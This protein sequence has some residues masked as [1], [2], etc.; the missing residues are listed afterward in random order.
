MKITPTLVSSFSMRPLYCDNLAQQIQSSG[1]SS[2]MFET[3]TRASLSHRLKNRPAKV[4]KEVG[5]SGSIISMFSS[6]T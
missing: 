2:L 5:T 3:K 4:I 6:A 1:Y